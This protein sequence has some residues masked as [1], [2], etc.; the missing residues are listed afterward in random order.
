MHRLASITSGLD[1]GNRFERRW[2]K[3][4]DASAGT[5]R[6]S[7]TGRILRRTKA[8][9]AVVGPDAVPTINRD[10]RDRGQSVQG[11]IIVEAYHA[12]T[13]RR[14]GDDDLRRR[15]CSTA[16]RHQNGHS[17]MPQHFR[18]HDLRD[19]VMTQDI[20]TDW[21][22]KVTQDQQVAIVPGFSDVTVCLK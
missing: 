16:R 22:G 21:L 9:I 7:K 20:L 12:A 19:T 2:C 17:C 8:F 1:A 4:C 11:R 13:G 6:F 5:S 18:Q 14:A 3:T 15:G 10:A